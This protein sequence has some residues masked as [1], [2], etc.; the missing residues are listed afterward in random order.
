VTFRI[1]F[2]PAAVRQLRHLDRAVQ[3]RLQGAIALLGHDPRPPAARGLRGRPGL[4]LRIGDYR[5]LYTVSDEQQL[6][7]VVAIGHRREVYR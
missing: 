3:L 1:E 5:F 7:V 4:R 2:R 6:V